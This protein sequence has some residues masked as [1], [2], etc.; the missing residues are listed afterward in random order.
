[1]SYDP[2]AL[3]LGQRHVVVAWLVCLAL[4]AACLVGCP[5]LM[6][7]HYDEGSPGF[8][9]RPRADPVE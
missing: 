6:F 2:A 7:R 8:G 9:G 4:S 5:G 1:M 3:F